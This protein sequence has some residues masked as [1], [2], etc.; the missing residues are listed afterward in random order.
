MLPLFCPVFVA[1]Q[2]AHPAPLVRPALLKS[3]ASVHESRVYSLAVLQ[4]V[5]AVFLVYQMWWVGLLASLIAGMGVYASVWRDT[6]V[7]VRGSRVSFV[8][9]EPG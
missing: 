2:R 3:G 4:F 7:M 8:A 1:A 6:K 5:L 9:V